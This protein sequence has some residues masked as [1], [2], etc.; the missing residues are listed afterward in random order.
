MSKMCT[1]RL[2]I[3]QHNDQ[4]THG[5]HS[6]NDEA[7]AVVRMALVMGRTV[8]MALGGGDLA[9]KKGMMMMMSPTTMMMT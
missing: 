3:A 8:M 5:R 4:H 7:L 2:T 6:Y 1:P 9:E